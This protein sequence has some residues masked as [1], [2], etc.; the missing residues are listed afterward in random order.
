MSIRKSI[1]AGAALA[2]A[3]S[4]GP[5]RAGVDLNEVGAF[6]VYPGVAAVNF[7]TP[8]E[9]Q[10]G[11]TVETFLTIT[12][13]SS[14]SIIAHVSFINGDEDSQQYCYECDFDVPMTGL[15]TETLVLTRS[16]YVTHILNL[17]T[18]AS[19]TCSQKI[20]FV[21]V[22]VEDAD[23]NVLTD[24]IL[25]G[26]E[27]IVDY[28]N[29]AAMSVPAISVQGDVGDGDRVFEFDDAEY[30]KFP[31]VVGADF[32]APDANYRLSAWLVLFT[33]AFDRQFP[34]LTDCSVIGF[35]A[36]E[37]QF[38]NS[39][40]FGCWTLQSLAHIDPEFAYPY[41]GASFDNQE[42]G[43]LQLTC[44]VFGTGDKNGVVDGGVHGA[45]AQYAFTNADHRRGDA[46]SP[47]LG[48]AAAWA[49]ILFQSGTVGDAMALTLE[50]PARGGTF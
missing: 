3:L 47:V 1:V 36:F 49:R 5:A 18:G 13:T 50:D 23:H 25:L 48:G 46:T 41:L 9:Q 15:D 42:H 45:I 27:V 4:F 35:D 33:L 43:W 10:V 32:L 20:G 7:G 40:Q 19:R 14:Q 38:S 37:E 16:G 21:T 44:T 2:L 34:P 28:T 24:N 31:S 11:L 30:R 26:S 39:F 6:L 29:G 8:G 17:D 22:D 12:N